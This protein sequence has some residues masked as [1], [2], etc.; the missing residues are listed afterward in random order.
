M[1]CRRFSSLLH[2]QRDINESMM[3]KRGPIDVK[4]SSAQQGD[5][6]S[7]CYSCFLGKLAS[8]YVLYSAFEGRIDSTDSSIALLGN[9]T[10]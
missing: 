5:E 7:R 8:L 4:R 3:N 6:R 2:C 9:K 1:A 10:Y